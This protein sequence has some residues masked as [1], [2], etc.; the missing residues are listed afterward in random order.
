MW[1]PAVVVV[2]D[3]VRALRAQPG[4]PR[5]LRDGP[6]RGIYAIGIDHDPSRLAEEGRAEVAFE[7]DGLTATV[8]V[9]GHDPVENVL[10]DQVSPAWAERAGPRAWRPFAM[11]A[12]R[13]AERSF[14]RRCASSTWSGVDLDDPGGVV[15]RWRAGGRTT[16][17]PVGVSIDGTFSLDLERDGPHALVAGTT[18][19]GKSEFLQ[20]LVASLALANRPDAIHFVLVD[21]KGA[22]AFADCA[23][24]PHTV[25][26]VTNL[27]GRGDAAGAGLAR[28]RA[29]PAGSLPAPAA[30]R[31][32]Q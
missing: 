18:G 15:N 29:A 12:A 31:R 32:R 16:L 4:V 13:R 6:A 7:A 1:T 30:G 27:D 26:L 9:D 23:E 14:R 2:L 8:R 22:S 21:Y 3:G 20:T 17:A 19:S 24:L 28:R 10:V 25:G 5:L 11:P